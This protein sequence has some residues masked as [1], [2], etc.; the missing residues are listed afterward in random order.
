M[1]QTT[2]NKLESNGETVAIPFDFQK[3]KDNI[4]KRL[5][6]ENNTAE[7]SSTVLDKKYR[8]RR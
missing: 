4:K 2:T 6:N 5:L 8:K 7:G 1:I 3:E